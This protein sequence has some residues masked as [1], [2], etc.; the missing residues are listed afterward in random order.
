VT[1]AFSQAFD[2]I[3]LTKKGGCK[4]E[5]LRTPI[6]DARAPVCFLIYFQEWR[7]WGNVAVVTSIQIVSMTWIVGQAVA[8]V[9]R[10]GH[11]LWGQACH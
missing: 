8:Q 2:R 10:K 1:L 7:T 6:S 5:M 9:K 3:V 4:P 11:P